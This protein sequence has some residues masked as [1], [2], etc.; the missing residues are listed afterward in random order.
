MVR[1]DSPLFTIPWDEKLPNEDIWKAIFTGEKK[2]PNAAVQAVG[3]LTQAQGTS[4][5]FARLQLPLLTH[6]KSWN[7]QVPR[8]FP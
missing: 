3:S 5:Y 4:S 6:F 2:P 7:K 8:W 1:W